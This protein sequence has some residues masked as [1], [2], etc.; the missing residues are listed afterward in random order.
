MVRVTRAINADTHRGPYLPNAKAYELQT[1]Y[2]VYGWR[3]TTRISHRR[4]YF[5]GQRSRSQGQ[6]HA[7]SLSRV[8]PMAHKSKTNSCSVTKIGRR[9]VPDD[10][11]YIAHQFQ[12]QKVKGQGHRPTNADTQNVPYFPN[13]R[14]APA[15]SAMTSKVIS[16]HRLYVSSLP[17]LNLGMK[18]LYLYY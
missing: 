11:C 16:S 2:L 18:M 1:W 3:T 5:R 14:P 17:L 6:G 9:R 8:G 13:G 4:H 12:G 7:I 10:T 15:V